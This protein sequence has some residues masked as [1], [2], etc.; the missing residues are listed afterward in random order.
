V[1]PALRLPQHICRHFD[2]EH[3]GRFVLSAASQEHGAK[4]V[5]WP[6]SNVLVTR[7]FSDSGV[8][9]VTDYMAVGVAA[10]R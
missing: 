8:A 6:D 5:Y 7:V 2:D 3:G 1:L 4:Q 9:E 10:E